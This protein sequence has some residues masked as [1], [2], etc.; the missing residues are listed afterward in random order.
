MES[1]VGSGSWAVNLGAGLYLVAYIVLAGW[2]CARAGRS[3]LWS[4]VLLYPPTAIIA[5][6]VFA[7]I[8]W[9]R[10]DGARGIPAGQTTADGG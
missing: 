8:R 5:I 6:W 7:Y 9:P 1:M 10:V 3:P 4:L 2:V